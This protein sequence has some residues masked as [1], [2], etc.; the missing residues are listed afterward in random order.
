MAEDSRNSFDRLYDHN[1]RIT[2]LESEYYNL[3]ESLEELANTI[4][5]LSKVLS[6]IQKNFTTIK[7]LSIGA[8]G[9]IILQTLGFMDFIKTAFKIIS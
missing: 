7:W 6:N 3:R 5:S 2:K 9:A 4:N 8:L 1:A